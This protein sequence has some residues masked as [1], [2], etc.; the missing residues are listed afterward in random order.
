MHHPPRLPPL[1]RNPKS[2]LERIRPR[3]RILHHLRRR[4]PNRRPGPRR[5]RRPHHGRFHHGPRRRPRQCSLPPLPHD[6]RPPRLPRPQNRPRPQTLPTRRSPQ[7]RH[8]P[9]RMD[10]RPARNSQR[11]LQSQ[12]SRR[13][14]PHLHPQLLRH[15]LQPAPSQSPHRPPPSRMAPRLQAHHRCHQQPHSRPHRSPRHNPHPQSRIHRILNLHSPIHNPLRSP[16][17]ALQTLRRHLPPLHPRRR[18]LSP[19]TLVR[20]LVAQASACVLFSLRCHPDRSG[21]IFSS[22]PH[23]GASGRA[24]EGP[25]Q[26]IHL[27]A[28]PR[29]TKISPRPPRPISASSALS[30][31]PSSPPAI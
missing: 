27:H 1:R 5:L 25:W 16:I 4:Q 11:P 13:H 29:S 6:R 28:V 31:L 20:L 2:R 8:P 14:R 24:V 3:N 22:A 18:R 17:L 23:F 10:L 9:D 30:P 12:S 21:P 7:P 15:H 26:P 19:P